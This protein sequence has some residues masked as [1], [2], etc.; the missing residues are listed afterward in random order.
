[1][2]S[3]LRLLGTFWGALVLVTLILG[4]MIEPIRHHIE[5]ASIQRHLVEFFIALIPGI[6][7]AWLSETMGAKTQH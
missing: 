7:M 3:L 2:Q 5:A 4:T 1:M 6:A